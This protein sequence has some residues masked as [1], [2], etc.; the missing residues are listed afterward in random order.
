MRS[1]S[2]GSW[3]PISL[4]TNLRSLLRP[5]LTRDLLHRKFSYFNVRSITVFPLAEVIFTTCSY[6]S[7]NGT[8]IPFLIFLFRQ[9]LLEKGCFEFFSCFFDNSD[10]HKSL[11]ADPCFPCFILIER[12]T[13]CV[14]VRVGREWNIFVIVRKLFLMLFKRSNQFKFLNYYCTL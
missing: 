12:S 2:K 3:K 1:E 14:V 13:N 4:R 10:W 11:F 8:K 5:N 6:A 7:C 9:R